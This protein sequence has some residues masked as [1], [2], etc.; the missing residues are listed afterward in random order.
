MIG[1]GHHITFFRKQMISATGS[2]GRVI[3]PKPHTQGV[4]QKIKAC[5]INMQYDC[6]QVNYTY[7][8]GAVKK[9]ANQKV[10][11]NTI[12]MTINPHGESTDL[13]PLRRHF[14]H[15]NCFPAGGDFSPPRREPAGEFGGIRRAPRRNG[16]RIS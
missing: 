9:S 16:D 8:V 6:I 15:N 12:Q 10:S 11:G 2:S 3:V 4:N 13:C 7:F 14:G 1:R 5:I